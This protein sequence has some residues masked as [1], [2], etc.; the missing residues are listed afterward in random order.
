MIIIEIVNNNEWN[1]AKELIME[2][3]NNPIYVVTNS[4]GKIKY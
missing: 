4:L 2:N 1:L 3:N